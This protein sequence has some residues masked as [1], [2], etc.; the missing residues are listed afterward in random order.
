V[1]TQVCLC[2]CGRGV[3]VWVGW[4]V[5][6]FGGGGYSKWGGVLLGGFKH[7]VGVGRQADKLMRG[8][9]SY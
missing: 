8:W 6:V 5:C 4:G 7:P 9:A 3:F 1:E 2:A